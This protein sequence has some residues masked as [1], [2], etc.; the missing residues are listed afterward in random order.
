MIFALLALGCYGMWLAVRHDRMMSEEYRME[1]EDIRESD[2]FSAW[3]KEWGKG[4]EEE[5]RARGYGSSEG[6]Q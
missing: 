1:G 5:H 3:I 6:E 2:E 4:R